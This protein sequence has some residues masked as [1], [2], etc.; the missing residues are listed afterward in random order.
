MQH[1]RQ[2]V[3]ERDAA[4]RAHGGPRQGQTTCLLNL[5]L[6]VSWIFKEEAN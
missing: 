4:G 2:V 5:R 6:E 3:P 1:L